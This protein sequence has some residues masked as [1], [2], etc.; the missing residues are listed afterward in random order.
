M[1]TE[2]PSVGETAQ[3][4]RGL[5][6]LTG[7]APPFD[8]SQV[9]EHP[10]DLFL[11]W[12]QEA[13]LAGV[14]EPHAA[15]LATAGADGMPDARTLIVKEVAAEGWAVAGPR[16]SRKA[17]QL[18]ENPAAALNF[19][20]QPLVRA[21]RVRGTVE[22]ASQ[23]E[24]DADLAARPLHARPTADWMVWWIRPT[25]VEFWQGAVSRNHTRLVYESDAGEWTHRVNAARLSEKGSPS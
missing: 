13:V 4:L 20:W 1:R 9:P 23:A 25:R 22:E 7:E 11:R 24:I 14:P 18:A 10:A 2:V 15:T 8:V 12:L 5:G 6:S 19:W 21:V 3:W 16:S 17:A